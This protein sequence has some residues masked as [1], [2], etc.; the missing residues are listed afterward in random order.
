MVL[1]K[2]VSQTTTGA[3]K[4]LVTRSATRQRGSERP[5]SAAQN[6]LYVP[7]SNP[8]SD[9]FDFPYPEPS[10]SDL[11]LRCLSTARA[12]A[13]AEPPKE[14]NDLELVERDLAGLRATVRRYGAAVASSA[15]E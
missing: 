15:A 14:S 11:A 6:G 13:T 12:L 4:K 8:C 2:S 7:L 9:R 3:I 1:M 5:P 10:S